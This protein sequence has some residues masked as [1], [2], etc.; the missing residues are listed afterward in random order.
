[1][2][3]KRNFLN[4]VIEAKSYDKLRNEDMNHAIIKSMGLVNRKDIAKNQANKK[5]IEHS[6]TENES[7]SFQQ[8]SLT[9]RSIGEISFEPKKFSKNVHEKSTLKKFDIKNKLNKYIMPIIIILN[10]INLILRA[11]SIKYLIICNI[12]DIIFTLCFI[13]EIIIKIS[14]NGLIIDSE[15]FLRNPINI[16]DLIITILSFVNIILNIIK[17]IKEKRFIIEMT[18][19]YCNISEFLLIH[20]ILPIYQIKYFKT[21]N[22]FINGCFGSI[23]NLLP[24]VIYYIFFYVLFSILGFHLWKTRFE[25]LCHEKTKPENGLFPVTALFK[26]TLCGGNNKCN[27]NMELCL[28][29]K[30]FYRNNVLNYQ[31]NNKKLYD[32][33]LDSIDFN[34]GITKYNNILYSLL[35]TIITSTGEGWVKIMTLIMDGHSYWVG[36]VYFFLFQL[37]FNIFLRNII[38]SIIIISFEKNKNN[39]NIIDISSNSQKKLSDQ[40]YNVKYKTKYHFFKKIRKYRK[41]I[42]QAMEY[43]GKHKSCSF[44]IFHPKLTVYHKKCLIFYWFYLA[45]EQ[46]LTQMIFFIFILINI[47]IVIFE[48]STKNKEINYYNSNG[49]H[50]SEYNFNLKIKYV[51]IFAYSF[52]QIFCFLSVGPFVFF[53]NLGYLIDFFVCLIVISNFFFGWIPTKNNDINNPSIIIGVI[54]VFKI[55]FNLSI[56]PIM[57]QVIVK[58]NI[59]GNALIRSFSIIPLAIIYLV[60]YSLFGYSLFHSSLTYNNGY[61]YNESFPTN[62]INFDNFLNS[63]L[64]T[65]IITLGDH[66]EEMFYYCYRSESNIRIFTIFY[67][68]NIVFIGQFLLLNLYEGFLLELCLGQKD[69]YD[70]N[71]QTKFYIENKHLETTKLY[72]L[73]ILQKKG[74]ERIL[75]INLFKLNKRLFADNGNLVFVGVSKINYEKYSSIMRNNFYFLHSNKIN[76]HTKEVLVGDIFKVCNAKMEK[77][78]EKVEKVKYYHF[79]V[80]YLNINNE[81]VNLKKFNSDTNIQIVKDGNRKSTKM[82]LK[83]L[84]D[85]SVIFS[86]IKKHPQKRNSVSFLSKK[87]ETYEKS[88]DIKQIIISEEQSTNS[89][90]HSKKMLNIKN[91]IINLFN[92]NEKEKEKTKDIPKKSEKGINTEEENDKENNKDK[93]LKINERK[94]NKEGTV[95]I[96]SEVETSTNKLQKVKY[97]NFINLLSN[98]RRSQISSFGNSIPNI[99]YRRRSFEIRITPLKNRLMK[100]LTSLPKRKIRDRKNS[101][102]VNALIQEE[103]NKHNINYEEIC[104][105]IW[106]SSLFIFHRNSKIRILCRYLVNLHEF[107]LIVK[108]FIII[109]TII[110]CFDSKWLDTKSTEKYIINIFDYVLTTFFVL[111]CLLRIISDDFIFQTPIQTSLKDKNSKL[112]KL[113]VFD[114]QNENNDD[115]ERMDENERMKSFRNSLNKIKNRKTYL[116]DPYNFIDFVC[117][118]VSVIDLFSTNKTGILFIFMTALRCL[119]PIRLISKSKNLKI[120]MSV[121]YNSIFSMLSAIILMILCIL[122][123]SIFGLYLFNAK[124][125]KICSLGLDYLTQEDCLKNNGYWVSNPNGYKTILY[126]FKITFFLLTTENWSKLMRD[127]FLLTENDTISFVFFPICVIILYFIIIKIIPSILVYSFREV[128][129]DD[130]NYE[131]L[132]DAEVQWVKVQ[133]DMSQNKPTTSLFNISKGSKTLK[134]LY[135]FINN[136]YYIYTIQ[137][138]SL[139]N[140]FLAFFKIDDFSFISYVMDILFSIIVV[141][142]TLEIILKMIVYGDSFKNFW[143]IFDLVIVILN[144]ISCIITVLMHRTNLISSDILN[145]SSIIVSIFS[146]VRVLRIIPKFEFLRKYSLVLVDIIKKFSGISFL[147]L[148]ITIIYANIGTNIFGLLPYRKYVN[149]VNNFENFLGSFIILLEI[150]TGGDWNMMMNEML[151]HDCRVKNSSIYLNDYYC[152]NYS[153]ICYDNGYINHSFLG[154][155]K[156]HS[157]VIFGNNTNFDLRNNINAYHLSCGSDFSYIF[158]ISYIMICQVILLCFFTMIILNNFEKAT[159]KQEKKGN[160]ISRF[161]NLWIEYDENCKLLVEPHEFVLIFKELPPPYGVNYD[162]LITDNPLKF[163]ERERQF[164]LFRNYLQLKKENS[165]LKHINFDDNYINHEYNHLPFAYQFSNFYISKNK[166]FF[167]YDLEMLHFLNFLDMDATEDKTGVV[168]TEKYSYLFEN[169][170]TNDLKKN[171]K[172]YIHYIDGCLALS[173]FTISKNDCINIFSLRDK[174]V[175]AYT[176]NRWMENF[177]NNEVMELFNSKEERNETKSKQM[178]FKLAPQILARSTQIFNKKYQNNDE[179]NIKGPINLKKERKFKRKKKKNEEKCSVLKVFTRNTIRSSYMLLPSNSEF[180]KRLDKERYYKDVFKR[181]ENKLT[182]VQKCQMDFNV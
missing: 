177:N 69:K 157:D 103:N 122:I 79:N 136:R 146:F 169:K 123:L 64:T 52:E 2:D 63:L 38:L 6:E 65:F 49:Y 24:A 94:L 151:Y 71:S 161:I 111:E 66:W 15:S 44:F 132:T 91:D 128:E 59:F 90:K 32:L 104:E 25:Y 156:E 134:Q 88:Q 172:Y 152:V 107:S 39:K 131:N 45:Y 14:F 149:R 102:L 180:L 20:L 163:R 166:K 8:N 46:Y 143:N 179:L 120:L 108:F 126:A 86:P 9:I 82:N 113:L 26:N 150:L 117:V 141:I 95:S 56:L 5:T 114:N 4:S 181:N 17:N 182:V 40:A 28:S 76:I 148:I 173:K 155:V 106:N 116:S 129:K 41:K 176:M 145:T 98:R 29:T 22:I 159:K 93:I 58:C 10:T 33:E 174:L 73:E 160:L 23:K 31:I 135:E 171:N 138:L 110:L 51:I 80:N 115:F 12:S 13:A 105:Y 78:K 167:T 153:I 178:T 83:N 168:S 127:I 162:R 74:K 37:I 139:L 77:E 34:Y 7:I 62:T 140:I 30:E 1:M 27:S 144:D 48:L 3:Q 61:T 68:F 55:F 67:Y 54:R 125:S 85:S 109:N 36:Y 57:K 72:Q 84:K 170:L 97:K 164:K 154:Y 130:T 118:I 100:H 175:N 137:I 35:T 18:T 101:I 87:I 70:L 119:K 50:S 112:S 92:I 42:T 53:K 165:D 19:N 11:Q 142:F 16:F 81:M 121:L 21:F 147:M 124:T 60:I 158:F 75:K 99:L 43:S 47:G 89:P 133:I 96:E